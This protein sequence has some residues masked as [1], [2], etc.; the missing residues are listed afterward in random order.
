MALSFVRGIG[1]ISRSIE[2]RKCFMRLKSAL[3]SP[4]LFVRGVNPWTTDENIREAFAPFG[5]LVEAKIMKDRL[6]GRSMGFAIVTYDNLQQAEKARRRV[7]DLSTEDK[8]RAAFAPFGNVLEA[9]IYKD[10]PNGNSKG[11]ATVRY[12]TKEEA[13]KAQ[14]ALDDNRLGHNTVVPVEP[15]KFKPSEQE[16]MHSDT[17]YIA[18]RTS[19]YTQSTHC[20]TEA[21]GGKYTDMGEVKKQIIRKGDTIN[22]KDLLFTKNRDYL[23]KNNNEQIKAEQ[24]EGKV[25]VIYFLPLYV[26]APQHSTTYYTSLLKEVYYDLLPKNNFEV[27]L[28]ANH[29]RHSGRKGTN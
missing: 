25:I 7:L 22:L 11:S 6:S 8:L 16:K 23:V 20:H 12:G 26:N 15:E 24:L 27:V 4:K 29:Y 18:H 14:D 28:V 5:N 10:G 3:T 19:G 21:A 1:I 17:S 9:R 2:C 13:E